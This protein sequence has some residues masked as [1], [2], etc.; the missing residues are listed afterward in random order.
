M[1]NRTHALSLTTFLWA[2][3]LA[4]TAGGSVTLPL[5]GYC[6]PGRYFPIQV[7]G[8][9]AAMPQFFSADGCLP[10][11]VQAGLPHRRVVPMLVTGFPTTLKGNRTGRDSMLLRVPKD[12]ERVIATTTADVSA[13]APLFSGSR[14]IAIRLDPTDPLPGPPAAW[15]TLDA[16]LL[17]AAEFSRI[18]DEE[19]SALLAGGVKLIC[20]GDVAPDARWPWQHKEN[21]WV[22]SFALAG[23]VGETVNEDAYAPTYAWNPGWRNAVRGQVMGAAILLVLITIALLLRPNRWTLISAIFLMLVASI[24]IA[25]WRQSLGN[26]TRAGGDVVVARAGLLQR[27]AWVYERSR[28]SSTQSV[29]WNNWTHPMFSS[30]DALRNSAMKLV[31]T[32]QG[33]LQFS[34]DAITGHTMAFVRR[35][36]WPG[37]MPVSSMPVRSPMLEL[38][39][40]VYL[41]AGEKIAGES[42][43]SDGRW[44]TIVEQSATKQAAK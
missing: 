33:E 4:S 39:K 15:E 14:I 31:V 34:H 17:D 29:A 12:D 28:E 10:T 32:A 41:G 36:I 27:D 38:A 7:D 19:R 2:C 18:P 13:A 35:E 44:P 40:S 3:L 1:E 11:L 9:D 26:I 16:V 20:T 25:A 8:G 22:L 21:A 6:R 37:E 24:G 30:D 43:G 42:P 5:Q 23:P